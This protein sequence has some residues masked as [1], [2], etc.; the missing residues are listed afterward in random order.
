[1]QNKLRNV[2]KIKQCVS[3]GVD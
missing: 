1:M 3:G 2:K